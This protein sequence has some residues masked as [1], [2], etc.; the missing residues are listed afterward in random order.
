M[1]LTLVVRVDLGLGRGKFAAQVAHAA[2]VCALANLGTSDF[3]PG[4]G[5]DHSGH[6]VPP[7]PGTDLHGNRMAPA[8]SR[9]S[10]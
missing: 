5:T 10:S 6:G 7:W 4:C 1:K 9:R 2:V 3:R 8:W